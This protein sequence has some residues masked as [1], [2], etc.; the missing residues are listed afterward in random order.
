M[1]PQRTQLSWN[2]RLDIKPTYKIC[3]Q[4]I[5]WSELCKNNEYIEFCMEDTF[6]EWPSSGTLKVK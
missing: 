1:Q 3:R 5:V 4:K 6:P 2:Q